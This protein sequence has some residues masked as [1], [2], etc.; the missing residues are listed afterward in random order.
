MSPP[1]SVNDP[2][3]SADQALGRL[4]EELTARLQAGEPIDL[5]ACIREH[6]E[7]AERLEKL[8]PALRMLADASASRSRGA[9]TCGVS[10][11]VSAVL[12]GELGDFQLL[13]E[14]YEQHKPPPGSPLQRWTDV[15]K[16]QNYTPVGILGVDGRWSYYPLTWPMNDGMPGDGTL[17]PTLMQ[18]IQVLI[19]WA[20][21]LVSGTTQPSA[22]AATLAAGPPPTRTVTA[23]LPSSSAA[24]IAPTG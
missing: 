11:E 6:P 1:A 9:S 16:P 20:G 21:E 5:Q 4:I 22:R 2:A 15:A 14:V 8:L 19:G 23:G 17:M 13:R 7:H 3:A 24:A 18:M 12:L 10:G